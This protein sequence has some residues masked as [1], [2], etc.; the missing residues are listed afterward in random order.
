MKLLIFLLFIA[1]FHC[2]NCTNIH[3]LIWTG[4]IQPQSNH[5]LYI[6]TKYNNKTVIEYSITNT[7]GDN[8]SLCIEP[9][10]LYPNLTRFNCLN[11]PNI[12]NL[13]T[14]YLIDSLKEGYHYIFIVLNYN[15]ITVSYPTV[16]I[17]IGNN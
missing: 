12:F 4:P 2:I 16:L 15:Y 14:K 7:V 8:L 10:Q 1:L 11:D 13:N 9:I 17:T 5:V 6:D 3:E